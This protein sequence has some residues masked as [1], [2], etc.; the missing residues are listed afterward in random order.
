[1]GVFDDLWTPP[2]SVQTETLRMGRVNPDVTTESV[3]QYTFTFTYKG[4]VKKLTVESTDA[5]G[6]AEVEDLVAEAVERWKAD[7]DDDPRYDKRLP[8]AEEK[9]QIGKALNERY[10][11]KQKIK[12]SSNGRTI[13]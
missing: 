13:Y 1:M 5:D 3:F 9:K 8:N 11:W 10:L 4:W 7:M 2:G 6:R 12:E